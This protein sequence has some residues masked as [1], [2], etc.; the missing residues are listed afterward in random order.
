M[1]HLKSTYRPSPE[2]ISVVVNVLKDIQQTKP[3]EATNTALAV[4]AINAGRLS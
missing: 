4:R 1:N 2:L 3:A